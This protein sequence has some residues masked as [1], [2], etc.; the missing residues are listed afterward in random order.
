METVTKSKRPIDRY[1]FLCLIIFLLI[2]GCSTPMA[3]MPT[4]T[5][6]LNNSYSEKQTPEQQRQAEIEL[7]YVTDRSPIEGNQKTYGSN[8]SASMAFGTTTVGF[9]NHGV[10]WNTLK[11]YSEQKK[12]ASKLFYAMRHVEEK[13]RFPSTPY[14]FKKTQKGV[15]I[16]EKV[17]AQKLQETKKLRN[18]VLK[19]LSQSQSK[20]VVLFVH[21][22]NNTFDEANFTLAGMWHFLNRQGVPITYSWPATSNKLLGYFMD[23]ESSEFTIFH[24]KETL[25]ILFDTPEIENIHL[26]AHSRGT[27]VATT[28]LRELLIEYRAAGKN[29]RKAFKIA[30]LI[31]AAPDLNFGVIKQRLMAEQF[32]IGFGQITVYTSD[33]DNALGLAQFMMKGIRFGRVASLDI[34]LN[35]RN[36]FERVGNVSLIKVPRSHEGKFGHDYFFSNPAVS[37][38]IIRIIQ[39]QAKP[40]TAPRPLTLIENNFWSLPANYLNK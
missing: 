29:P 7:V 40:G 37:S 28:A 2:S 18:I 23:R 5:I 13:G 11:D 19:K 17:S 15:Q 39:T 10:D 38:D 4:P 3:L 32:G 6:F 16:D 35:E 31:L 30:N 14:V 21:G 22:Y 33:G 24:L 12:R 27:D 26:I 1:N 25:R 8:R 20:D 34:G 36:I 9:K